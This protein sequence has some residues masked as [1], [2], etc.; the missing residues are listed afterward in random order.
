MVV[1]RLRLEFAVK[2]AM[3]IGTQ[4]ACGNLGRCIKAIVASVI[5]EEA[6]NECKRNYNLQLVREVSSWIQQHKHR[7]LSVEIIQHNKL[8]FKDSEGAHSQAGEMQS[9]LCKQNSQ[10][11]TGWSKFNKTHC[12]CHVTTIE[13]L[14]RHLLSMHT[15]IGLPPWPSASFHHISAPPWWPVPGPRSNPVHPRCPLIAWHSTAK[16]CHLCIS[17]NI[18]RYW[19][20]KNTIE[21]DWRVTMLLEKHDW[22]EDIQSFL[23]L[24]SIS[25][26]NVFKSHE[27]ASE[28]TIFNES[29]WKR[30]NIF[31]ILHAS[32][33]LPKTLNM[34]DSPDKVCWQSSL[35]CGDWGMAWTWYAKT[36]TKVCHPTNPFLVKLDSNHSV[37]TNHN[38]Q[39]DQVWYKC[40]QSII[41]IYIL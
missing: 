30:L 13:K 23:W 1:I 9:W 35:L 7:F 20:W 36:I 3:W 38:L 24:L 14:K 21:D 31:S 11:M 37:L 4:F 16:G 28:T 26:S 41:Y 17:K 34:S 19:N 33:P 27:K 6:A 15:C 8:F 18:L 22:I 5:P 25:I 39:R 10:I 40:I 29:N 32:K 12:Q 2:A